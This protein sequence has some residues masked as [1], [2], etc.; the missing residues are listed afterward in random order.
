[1]PER[2]TKA[3]TVI[4]ATR[5]WPAPHLQVIMLRS[6]KAGTVIPATQRSTDRTRSGPLGRSTK[7]G[8]VIPATRG[9]GVAVDGVDV[10]A[11]RRPG[12]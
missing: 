10:H 7:A 4:P 1:M 5:R 9:T 3:G 6:T 12:P 2:S 11:Q 8:T